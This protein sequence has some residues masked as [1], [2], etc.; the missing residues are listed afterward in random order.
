MLEVCKEAGLSGVVFLP[1]YRLA[2]AVTQNKQTW[3]DKGS[4]GST[5]LSQYLS[6]LG[7]VLAIALHVFLTCLNVL[8]EDVGDRTD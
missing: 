1:H 6:S 5:S 4:V 3:W 8:R 2:V 7:S